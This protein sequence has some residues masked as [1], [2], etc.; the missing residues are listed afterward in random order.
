[1]SRHCSD[2]RQRASK[3]YQS[4][5]ADLVQYKISK[6]LAALEPRRERHKRDAAEFKQKGA[7]G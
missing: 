3:R 5:H 6:Q 2:S 4:I 1:M 7:W